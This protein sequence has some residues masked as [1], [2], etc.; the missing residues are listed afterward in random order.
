MT[1][2]GR[3]ARHALCAMG[4]ILSANPVMAQSPN[5]DLAELVRQQAR[6]IDQLEQRVD[7]L[8]ASRASP[9]DSRANDEAKAVYKTQGNTPPDANVTSLR[10]EVEQLKTAQA[11]SLQVDWSSGA[12]KF[13]SP[14][15]DFSFEP[16]GRIQY[17]YSTTG[18]SSYEARDINGTEFR[19]LRLGVKGQ[20]MDPIFYILQLD[21]TDSDVSV[22]SAYIG[23]DFELGENSIDLALGN[24]FNDRS[25][26]GSTSSKWIWFLERNV[27]AN[28]VIPENG[29]FLSG[30]SAAVYGDGPWHASL[31]VAKG[32]L[33]DDNTESDN[34][35]VLSRAH[36]N[37]LLTD[38]AM[39]H[40]GAW[41]FYED[42]ERAQQPTISQRARVTAHFNDN[43]RVESDTIDRPKTST[44]YGFELAGSVGP[45]ATAAEYGRRDID[46][47]PDSATGDTDYD[48]YAV[49]A[50]YFLTG[51][52]HGYS[53]K[54]G[55]WTRPDIANPV[56]QGGWGAWE[57]LARYEALDY[58]NRPLL[59]G[60]TGHDTTVGLNWWVNAYTR[61]MFNWTH[62]DTNNRVGEFTGA[63]DGDTFAARAQVVF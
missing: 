23:T 26:S 59:R 6:K 31:Q 48:A 16:F 40:L 30:A 43:V 24:K 29:Y 52:K 56:T 27:V 50:G 7:A 37:P 17:D 63:D 3:S 61:F 49:Q 35:T 41:G 28:N 53:G 54:S 2:H 36:Y 46:T 20:L 19:R 10:R 22:L 45:F 9:A 38:N 15:G 57:V 21:F 12:P 8:S 18:G 60:G 42:F 25:L 44:G 14:E 11:N 62:W 1:N 51:E 32:S 33:S 5:P 58:D 4:L 47:R 34:T 39:V 13:S 55:V